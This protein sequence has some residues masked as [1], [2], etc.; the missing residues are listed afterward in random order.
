MTE[1][2]LYNPDFKHTAYLSIFVHI[3]TSSCLDEVLMYCTL[4]KKIIET[5]YLERVFIDH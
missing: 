4:D 5:P 3:N 2:A 1:N